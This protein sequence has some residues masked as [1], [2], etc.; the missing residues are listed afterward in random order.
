MHNGSA[1]IAVYDEFRAQLAE[2][3]QHNGSVVF[4]YDD[5]QGNKEARSH[6]YKLRQTKAAVDRVRKAEKQASLD[7]GRMVDAQAKEIVT[8]IEGMIE[9]H[10]K[11]LD[12]IDQREKERQAKHEGRI[13]EMQELAMESNEDVSAAALRDRLKQLETYKLG[14]HWEEYEIEAAR[15]KE[16]GIE[17]L[18][19]Q[20]ERREKYEA[21]QAELARLRR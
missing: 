9:V 19:R 13:A 8:E 11:P 7:Y 10:Q 4:D 20:I 14:E 16:A 3:R 21:E 2:L 12:E 5:P 6:I 18:K 17:A 1:Q 15:V